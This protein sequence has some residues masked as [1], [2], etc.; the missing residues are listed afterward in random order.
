ML[1]DSLTSLTMPDPFSSIALGA[2]LG[3]LFS[4]LLSKD[5]SREQRLREAKVIIRGMIQEVED[6]HPGYLFMLH[7]S[8]SGKVKA[9]GNVVIDDLSRT[10]QEEFGRACS[11]FVN[12]T[13]SERTPVVTPFGPEYKVTPEELAREQKNWKKPTELLN[14]RLIA[15]L[16]CL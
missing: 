8:L 15:I 9:L 3:S 7:E 2:G 6:H 14:A 13:D 11:E 16:N 5:V 1:A 4:H 12:T 10:Q